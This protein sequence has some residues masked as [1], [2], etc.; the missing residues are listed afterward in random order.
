MFDFFKKVARVNRAGK[1]AKDKAIINGDE[2][3]II[4]AK[5][6]IAR[7][8]EKQKIASEDNL[9]TSSKTTSKTYNTTKTINNGVNTT[10]DISK[11]K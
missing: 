3:H 2:D 5:V 10:I 9:K 1:I 11:K 7:N 8:E 6:R 4:K